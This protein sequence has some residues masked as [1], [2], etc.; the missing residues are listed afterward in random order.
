MQLN[1][2]Q[3]NFTHVEV[4]FLPHNT[5]SY[6]QPLDTR[7]IP[8]VTDNNINNV[9]QIYQDILTH[10]KEDTNQIIID[11][12][13]DDS[14]ANSLADALNDFFYS[15][16]EKIPTK[17]ILTKNNIINLTQSEMCSKNVNPSHSDNSEKKPEVVSL[18]DASKSLHTW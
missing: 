9:T 12:L 8:I 2:F 11:N 13:Y 15:L 10:E 16:D 17:D 3:L 5:T 1:T 7:I 6:L 18:N 4:T 14:Y